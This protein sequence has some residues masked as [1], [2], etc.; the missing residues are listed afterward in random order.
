MAT[1][2]KP[3]FK[4]GNWN[5]KKDAFRKIASLPPQAP[6]D[7]AEQMMR[8]LI[9]FPHL[10]K[11]LDQERRAYLLK[12]AEQR[13]AN[14]VELMKDLLSQCDLCA[15]SGS[16][17]FAL[18]QEQLSQSDFADWYEI[19]RLRVMDSNLSE[20]V[21]KADLEG[22]LQKI[23]LIVLKNEMTAITQKLAQNTATEQD[24]ERYRELGDKLRG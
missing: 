2:S 3:A 7:L 14:A 5:T 1:G 20:E 13:S 10:G 19:L 6:T 23:Q 18:F 12:A 11:A 9:Q 22:S 21:A 15:E 4:P 17:N 24:R 8:V 16:A